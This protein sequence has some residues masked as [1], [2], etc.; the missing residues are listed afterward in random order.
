MVNI[1]NLAILIFPWVLLPIRGNE[2]PFRLCKSSFFDIFCLAL[3]AYGIINGCHKK[4]SNKYLGYFSI[5]LF[6]TFIFNWYFPFSLSID[7][8][9]W[10][11]IS[12]LEPMLHIILALFATYIALSNLE[13]EDFPKIT[14]TICYSAF[15][16]ASFC[17]F[18]KF[19]FDPYGERFKGNSRFIAFFGNP[20][21]SA[22]YLA[23]TFPM[24]LFL[25]EKKFK[26]MSMVVIASILYSASILSII[27]LII[28]FMVYLIV[29]YRAKI[30]VLI[31]I[32]I[33]ISALV[34]SISTSKKYFKI[35]NGFS[36]RIPAWSEGIKHL[37]K[38]PLFGQGV[39]IFKTFD[40]NVAGEYFREAHNDWLERTCEIG[41]LGLFLMVLTI[42]HSL[43]RFNYSKE[44]TTGFPFLISFIAFLF[45]MLGS[46]PMEIAPIA[47]IGLVCFWAIELL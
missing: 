34:V 12:T 20:N 2:D 22:N 45:I 30:K 6:I 26:L 7:N 11:N 18:Q 47:M 16:V 46:F 43:R 40:V 1:I 31:V 13:K 33:L 27:S 39:G 3:I 28:T 4:Y 36:Y 8:K 41:F 25:K 23:V 19:G 38:N 24:F 15:L 35:E 44:N 21:L 42:I 10:L 14:K 29:K 37:K 9:Q 17:L 5:Y 32:A